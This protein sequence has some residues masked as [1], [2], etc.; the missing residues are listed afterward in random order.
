MS[1]TNSL[2]WH[3]EPNPFDGRGLSPAYI[4]D[5]TNFLE[6]HCSLGHTPGLLP[7]SS[8]RRHALPEFRTPDVLQLA[9]IAAIGECG[10]RI[11]VPPDQSDVRISTLNMRTLDPGTHAIYACLAPDRPPFG[12]TIP[13]RG[14][15]GNGPTRHHKWRAHRVFLATSDALSG[16]SAEPLVDWLQVGIVHRVPRGGYLANVLDCDYHPPIAD[17]TAY[18]H[19][20]PLV[21]LSERGLR[22][23]EELADASLHEALRRELMLLRNVAERGRPGEVLLQ[24]QRCLAMLR[25]GHVEGLVLPADLEQTP[26][27][28]LTFCEFLGRLAAALRSDASPELYPETLH[29]GSERWMKLD[30]PLHADG[31][32][33]LRWKGPEEFYARGFLLYCPRAVRGELPH[34]SCGRSRQDL[35]AFQP[36]REL[37]AAAPGVAL[38]LEGLR[39]SVS[40]FFLKATAGAELNRLEQRLGEGHAI[41]YR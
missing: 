6:S 20:N 26:Y 41:Y 34:V 38:S 22:A 33:F 10:H 39:G 25:A 1:P 14:A 17:M 16:S 31:G 19:A 9:S 40:G 28:P 30:E 11:I 15:N 24:T 27:D 36:A 29:V 12:E 37:T 35:D 7:K 18:V 13:A 23:C 4:N 8:R 3:F 21:L 2:G 5:Y 32:G